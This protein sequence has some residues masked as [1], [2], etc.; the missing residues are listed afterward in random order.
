[1]KKLTHGEN[2][3][4]NPVLDGTGNIRSTE[5]SVV[6]Q[7]ITQACKKR[8]DEKKGKKND[9]VTKSAGEEDRLPA[10]DWMT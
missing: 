7:S 2:D 5:R 6:W 8:G 10:R 4:R 9:L 1:M 3:A